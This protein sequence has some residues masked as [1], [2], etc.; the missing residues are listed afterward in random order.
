MENI[1]PSKPI[2]K[3]VVYDAVRDARPE[4]IVVYCSDPRFQTAFDQFIQKE[5]GLAKGQFMPLIIGGGAGV[6]GHP[7][8]LPKEFKFLKERFELYR[9]VFPSLRRVVLINHEDCR[10]YE[11]L[12]NKLLGFLGPRFVISPEH[13]RDDLALVSKAFKHLLPH[14]GFTVEFFYARFADTQRTKIH[15]EKVQI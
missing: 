11:Y 6:L 12:K 7:E 1:A 2:E 15:F 14:L 3:R 8:Q 4:A 9:E 13:A 10:Y 5:L